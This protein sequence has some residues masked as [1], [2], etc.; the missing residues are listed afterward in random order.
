MICTR[1]LLI[2]ANRTHGVSITCCFGIP[3]HRRFD[4]LLIFISRRS[5]DLPFGPFSALLWTS[6]RREQHR[7]RAVC[8]YTLGLRHSRC[9]CILYPCRGATGSDILLLYGSIRPLPC[10]LIRFLCHYHPH[11][12]LSWPVEQINASLQRHNLRNITK[13]NKLRSTYLHTSSTRH[14]L[15]SPSG[16]LTFFD[17]FSTPDWHH[18]SRLK[19]L[20]HS[21]RIGA[22]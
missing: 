8:T 18:Y 5:S 22:T 16:L 13:P 4:H 11:T 14:P 6:G 10:S 21:L 1:H 7:L 17:T 3:Q 20:G 9:F 19:A 15:L 2:T 12:E